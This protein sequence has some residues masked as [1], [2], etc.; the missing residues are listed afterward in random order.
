[1]I[2]SAISKQLAVLVLVRVTTPSEVAAPKEAD[3]TPTVSVPNNVEGLNALL[4]PQ[5]K[6]APHQW[7]VQLECL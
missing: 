3:P 5:A 1:M 4:P 6:D 7:L 2:T